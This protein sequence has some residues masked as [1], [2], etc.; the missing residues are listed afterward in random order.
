M[1]TRVVGAQG[2]A[3]QSGDRIVERTG[4]LACA[5]LRVRRERRLLQPYR[6]GEP[7]PPALPPLPPQ[8]TLTS[9]MGS[10]RSELTDMKARIRKQLDANAQVLRDMAARGDGPTRA[11]AAVAAGGSAG[12]GGD[13]AIASALEAQ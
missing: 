5:S 6:V 10:L 1:A 2:N 12:G 8:A 9:E 13:S 7:R 3:R 11:L 4:V